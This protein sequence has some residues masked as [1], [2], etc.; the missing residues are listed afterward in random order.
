VRHAGASSHG[1]AFSRY[2]EPVHTLVILR[3]G[4]SLWNAANLFTGWVDVDLSPKGEEEARAA[5]ALLAAESGLVIDVVHT[6]VLTRAVHTSDLALAVAGRSYLPVHR[7]WRLNERHY[8]RLQGMNK[9]EAAERFGA[10]QVKAWRRGY[11]TPPDPV[12][13]DDPNHP[14]N[15]PRYALIPPDALP[16]SECLA[17]VVRR[18][19]PYFEDRIGK[20]LLEGRTVLVVAHGN[21]LRALAKYIER[22]SDEN[23]VDLDIPTGVPRVYELD[24]DLHVV[25]ARYLGDPEAIRAAAEAVARQAG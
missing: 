15:D 12:D 21:S 14:V 18:L 6:S 10:D 25:S 17:D 2:P 24:D 11:L 13:V 5:G 22:I 20:D 9:K 16:G 4:E 8:G 23:I 3:H 1:A 19:I 7:H